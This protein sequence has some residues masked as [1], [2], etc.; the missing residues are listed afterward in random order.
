MNKFYVLK[1]LKIGVGSCVAILIAN[2]FGLA[3]SASA[4]VITLL[5]IQDTKKETMI[6]ALRRFLTFVIAMCIAGIIFLNFGYNAITF[7]TFLLGFISVCYTLKLEDSIAMSAVLTTHFLAEQSM[8]FYWIR[9]ELSLMLI[10]VTISIFLNMF[11]PRN[12]E[13]IRRDQFEIEEDMKN[14][15]NRM[16][17][18]I[19][20]EEQ[21]QSS[22]IC[23][24]EEA[25]LNEESIKNLEEHLEKAL[26]RAYKNMNNTLLSDTR[27]YIGYME[28]RKN[29]CAILK[30]I[31]AQIA[32]LNAVP[33][34][35][36]LISDLLKDMSSSFHEYNNAKD[37]LEEL[38]LI[39]EKFKH[40]TL[41]TTRN[42]FENRA[43]LYYILN[44]LELFLT[45]KKDFVL[46]LSEADINTFWNIENPS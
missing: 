24:R 33:A 25:G 45:M 21:C 6:L 27:Y 40:D 23:Y 36:Y 7:G 2:Y 37:L 1:V 32:L 8:S 20:T 26:S 29:Q 18:N 17:F 11:M 44:D 10:G 22:E 15:L 13:E 14:I 41:P 35:A 30:D 4:G 3:Y 46:S 42:E 9:N 12:I 5:S 16:A 34:Q 38:N 19:L 39:K 31:Y 28:V 43:I